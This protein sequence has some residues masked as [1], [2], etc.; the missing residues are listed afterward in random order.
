MALIIEEIQLPG[1]GELIAIEA[2]GRAEVEARIA[3]AFTD[4]VLEQDS[5][6]GSEPGMR[7]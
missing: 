1:T 4:V 7:L 5:D 3:A 6:E 2:S